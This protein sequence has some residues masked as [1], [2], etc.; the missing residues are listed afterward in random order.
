MIL[1]QD[2]TENCVFR[3]P[4]DDYADQVVTAQIRDEAGDATQAMKDRMQ[5]IY[6][7]LPLGVTPPDSAF[8]QMASFDHVKEEEAKGVVTFT[9]HNPKPQYSDYDG[10]Y[11]G[12]APL[13]IIPIFNSDGPDPDIKVDVVCVN[14]SFPD[15]YVIPDRCLS[16][17]EFD[18][19]VA[20][21]TAWKKEHDEE[22]QQAQKEAA[23]EQADRNMAIVRAMLSKPSTYCTGTQ[24]C[25]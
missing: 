2:W 13:P 9:Y 12:Y 17:Q 22:Q 23:D 24:G 6:N 10:K 4:P 5:S 7:N 21:F 3:S 19:K 8:G 18:S 14:G 25:N 11:F 1:C 16:M 15:R 20:E